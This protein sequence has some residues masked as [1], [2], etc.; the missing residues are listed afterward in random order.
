MK[1]PSPGRNFLRWNGQLNDWVHFLIWILACPNAWVACWGFIRFALYFQVVTVRS[2]AVLFTN[3]WDHLPLCFYML[4][5]SIIVEIEYNKSFG[6][7]TLFFQLIFISDF[8]SQVDFFVWSLPYR[9]KLYKLLTRAI[10]L[11]FLCLLF[12]ISRLNALISKRCHHYTI[13]RQRFLS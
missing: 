6:S 3:R 8:V 2:Y 10:G 9:N 7:Q 5:C 13:V 11:Y 12:M 4:H 1:Q